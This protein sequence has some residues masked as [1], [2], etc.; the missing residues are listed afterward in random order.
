[1]RIQSVL[2]P[3][4]LIAAVF[5]LLDARADAVAAEISLSLHPS[6]SARKVWFRG[7]SI[8]FFVQAHKAD[9]GG[10]LQ[11]VAAIDGREIVLHR[12]P[13][14]RLEYPLRIQPQLRNGQ[15]VL[16][17]RI[18]DGDRRIDSERLRLSM[19]PPINDEFPIFTF[20]IAKRNRLGSLEEIM[21]GYRAAGY[22]QAYYF[23][24]HEPEL[25]NLYEYEKK[26]RVHEI[27]NHAADVGMGLVG[28]T[29]M[30]IHLHLDDQ[31]SS[32]S[33]SGNYPHTYVSHSGS[34]RMANVRHPHV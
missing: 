22:N 14:Q 6:Y 26:P 17:A 30:F 16:W 12:E 23:V 11:L 19:R 25:G 24:A 2:R 13:H 34:K 5:A 18:V 27:L 3:V 4:L 8:P 9:A 15:Y 21:N 31:S 28:M 33:A 20:G 32:V 29:N 10:E 7:E 1:M